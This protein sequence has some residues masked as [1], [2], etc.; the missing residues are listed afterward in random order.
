MP[1]LNSPV[2]QILSSIYFGWTACKRAGVGTLETQNTAVS[3]ESSS[4]H[5][6]VS[7]ELPDLP[8]TER[9]QS[10]PSQESTA[11]GSEVDPS[12]PVAATD[13]DKGWSHAETL[14]LI[15]TY[16][17]FRGKFHDQSRKKKDVWTAIASK[18]IA[19]QNC[20][21]FNAAKCSKKWNNLEIRYRE[22]RDKKKKTGR[23]GGKPWIFYEKIDSIIG[24]SA[25]AA[26][27][28]KA[29][30]SASE[31][32]SAAPS[33][34]APDSDTSDEEGRE[35]VAGV[36]VA[37]PP[38]QPTASRKGRRDQ[39]PQWLDAMMER[40]EGEQKRRHE[41]LKEML[42]RQEAAMNERTNVMKEMKDIFKTWVEKQQ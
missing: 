17:Q 29:Y 27:V 37:T 25:S 41:E 28:S 10:E 13:V 3:V 31:S 19:V 16:H 15:E 22:K 32:A 1:I 18:M 33:L 14:L 30:V 38:Q 20:D 12:D 39:P 8:P 36:S 42:N 6:Q 40:I 35:S 23:G 7:V 11:E 24:H 21:K 5:S 2:S 34:I 9:P 4:V 26:S